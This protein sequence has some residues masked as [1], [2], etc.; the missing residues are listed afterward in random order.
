[1]LSDWQIILL[2]NGL[3]FLPVLSVVACV[4]FPWKHWNAL[5]DSM[6]DDHESR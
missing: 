1:M 2:D 5:L 3:W 4:V 6:E